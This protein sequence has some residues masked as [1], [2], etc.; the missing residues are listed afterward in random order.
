MRDVEQ[1]AGADGVL[2]AIEVVQGGRPAGQRIT[3]P[4]CHLSADWALLLHCYDQPDM[5]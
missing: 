4:D 1:L 2:P 5:S 3:S